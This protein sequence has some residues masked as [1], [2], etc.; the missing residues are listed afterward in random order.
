MFSCS[1]PRLLLA[2]FGLLAISMIFVGAC[3]AG[4]PKSGLAPTTD[5]PNTA[6]VDA[7]PAVATV[8]TFSGKKTLRAK[9]AA[10]TPIAPS[11]S[12]RTAVNSSSADGSV[13][14][15]GSASAATVYGFAAP[16]LE[17]WTPSEQVQQLTAMKAT[18]VTSVRIDA[19]WS[20]GQPDGPDSYD[21]GPLDQAFASIRKAG[22]SADLIIDGCPSWAAV[23]GAQGNSSAEPASAAAFAN[24]GAA[25]A[26]RYGGE[27]AKYFEIWNEPNSP[28][29]WAPKPDPAAYTA[30]LRAAYTAIKA[31]DPSAV[32]LTGGLAPELDSST[33]YAPLTFLKDMYANG[34]AGSFDGVGFHPYSYPEDPDTDIAESAWSQLSLTSPSVRSIMAA[35]G[36]SAKKIWIT[37]FGAPTSGMPTNVSEADQSDELFQAI[38]QVKGLS[39]VGSFYIYTWEDV[40]NEGFGLLA[41]DG[42]QKPAY[43]AVVAALPK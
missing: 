7:T 35:N 15:A 39:W 4:A 11:G 24:W 30:D 13:T 31:V 5:A 10:S 32:V 27:G 21:W 38:S 26:K 8:P 33:S 3:A 37:E 14:I 12:G 19:D 36:D 40:P 25:V 29:F 18:G 23:S 1:P 41:V 9:S 22:L 20:S 17:S 43:A 2:R 34:A 16:E 6:S 42:T 28:E